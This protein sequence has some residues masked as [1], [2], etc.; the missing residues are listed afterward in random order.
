MATK[1]NTRKEVRNAPAMP[2]KPAVRR[3]LPKAPV[4]QEVRTK[5]AAVAS[6]ANLPKTKRTTP[7]VPAT[8]RAVA[9]N[10]AVVKPTAPKTVGKSSKV[11][12]RLYHAV[13]LMDEV[14]PDITELVTEVIRPHFSSL[15]GDVTVSLAILDKAISRRI[16]GTGD[17]DLD[18]EKFAIAEGELIVIR[19]HKTGG[20][21]IYNTATAAP[22]EMVMDRK[23]RS[24]VMFTVIPTDLTEFD[25]FVTMMGKKLESYGMPVK[26]ANA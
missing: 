17:P 12:G 11:I 9:V 25:N 8:K 7:V 23:S 22:V 2:A 20:V 16:S 14:G 21:T 6:D 26:A 4:T 3:V 24:S 13:D 19:E 18:G 5:V 15:D 1:S 10:P